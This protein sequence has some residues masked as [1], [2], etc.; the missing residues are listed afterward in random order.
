MKKINFFQR[1]ALESAHKGWGESCIIGVAAAGQEISTR[2]FQLVTGRIWKGTAF[3]GWKSL[4]SVPKLVEDYMNK[5]IKLDEFISHRY[6]KI[7]DLNNAFDE[8]HNG[9]G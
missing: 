7:D 6:E 9:N 2:P 8:L 1:Q 4:D 3:G 5:K